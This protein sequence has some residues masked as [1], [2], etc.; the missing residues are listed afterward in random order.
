MFSRV[1]PS[2][3]VVLAVPKANFKLDLASLA[4]FKMNQEGIRR[5]VQDAIACRHFPPTLSLPENECNVTPSSLFQMPTLVW[6]PESLE[7]NWK[8]P[9]SGCAC[10]PQV[11][12]YMSRQVDDV[13][14]RTLLLFC[15][16]RCRSTGDIFST[17]SDMF[18]D[19]QLP[20]IT[21]RF[22][23]IMTHKFGVSK[24]LMCTIHEGVTSGRGVKSAIDGVMTVR[25]NRFLYLRSLFGVSVRQRR[26]KNPNYI[27]PAPPSL[28]QYSTAHRLSDQDTVTQLWLS[29]S[30]VYSA[31]SEMVMHAADIKKLVRI[32]HSRKFT[33]LL[34]K[35]G[36]G[37]KKEGVANFHLL[38][39]VQNECG[40]IVARALT[41]S[42]NNMETE[43]VLV[44]KVLPRIPHLSAQ[45]YFLVSDNASAVRGT[46]ERVFGS[47]VQTK[48]DPF[49]VIQRFTEKV[50]RGNERNRVA[51]ALST[52]L[53]HGNRQL[54]DA[55]SMGAS[56]QEAADTVCDKELLCTRDEWERTLAS[57]LRQIERGDMTVK[58]NFYT[59]N[60]RSS[61][62]ISTSQLEGVHS[63]LKKALSHPVSVGVGLRVLDIFLL[64]V[65]LLSTNCLCFGYCVSL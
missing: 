36:E 22:P 58:D 31:L 47:R 6:V 27:S 43:S 34:K 46:V 20:E 41:S 40:Q 26:D 3:P 35:C 4:H 28:E 16:Y 13:E 54:R 2:C 5:R 25:H 60:G 14:H 23:Y 57:N 44:E 51:K 52:A 42:E 59:E 21:I 17:V 30:E 65:S 56:M 64:E 29:W 49:H 7:T 48:Q 11:K 62:V 24:R 45:E 55:A 37:G 53:Y 9:K 38:L 32:D 19:A 8:C 10:T 39:L 15:K 12:G 33:S 63:Q 1:V 50:R 61:K 18:L